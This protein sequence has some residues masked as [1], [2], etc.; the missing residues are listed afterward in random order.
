M[1]KHV[2]R[3]SDWYKDIY[4]MFPL[5]CD[6]EEVFV[7]TAGPVVVYLLLL[8]FLIFVILILHEMLAEQVRE[9]HTTKNRTQ[10]LVGFCSIS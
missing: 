8:T 5:I 9:L 3:K 10:R 7:S 6:V 4:D 1:A 2:I